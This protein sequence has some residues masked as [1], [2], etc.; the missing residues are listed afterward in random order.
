MAQSGNRPPVYAYRRSAKADSNDS[1]RLRFLEHHL[2]DVNA[3]FKALLAFDLT[4]VA[5]S[6]TPTTHQQANFA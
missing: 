6:S 3:C 2:A 4:S 5:V 1:T